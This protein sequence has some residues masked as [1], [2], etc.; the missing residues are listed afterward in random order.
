MRVPVLQQ[1]GTGL[2]ELTHVHQQQGP[3]F[4]IPTGVSSCTHLI[5]LS[6]SIAPCRVLCQCSGHNSYLQGNQLT[7]TAGTT[8]IEVGLRH[9]CRVVELDVYDGP[10]EPVR[11][12]LL[13]S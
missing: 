5:N 13:L 1:L 2:P 11:T 3:L 6:F 10:T 9:G 12:V 4:S 8:T 7:S